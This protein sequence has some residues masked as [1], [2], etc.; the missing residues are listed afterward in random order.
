MAR[1]AL[2]ARSP[3]LELQAFRREFLRVNKDRN[4]APDPNPLMVRVGRAVLTCL[5][6]RPWQ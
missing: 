6:R 3:G 4:L 1:C 5:A 2:E